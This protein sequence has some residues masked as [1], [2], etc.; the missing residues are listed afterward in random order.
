[1]KSSANILLSK[2]ASAK[3]RNEATLSNVREGLGRVAHYKGNPLS[4][5]EITLHIDTFFT[6]GNGALSPIFAP[7]GLPA[8]NQFSLPVYLFGLTDYYAGYTKLKNINPVSGN[9]I[10]FNRI[11][12]NFIGIFNS[13]FTSTGNAPLDLQLQDGDLVMLFSSTLGNFLGMIRIRCNNVAYG[14]FLN[15]FV[16]DLITLEMIRYIV[17]IANINQFINPIIF[18][19]QSLFGKTHTDNIDPRLYITSRDFQQQI[20]D[21]P[22]HMP[23]DKTLM[24]GF[25]LDVFCQNVSL[26]LFVEKVEALTH[27]QSLT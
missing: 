20:A 13:N 21:I 19:T 2:I 3:R 6:N 25:Q 11:A 14:T 18:G 24:M 8:G 17:P 5:T 15:S 12:Q 10:F 9:W 7:A 1:L 26:V 23:I 22:V 16:S 27:K 4:K